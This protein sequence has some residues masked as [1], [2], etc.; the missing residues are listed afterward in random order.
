MVIGCRICIPK[1]CELKRHRG[2]E[3]K[4]EG[5]DV[6]CD[7][8]C[9]LGRHMLEV[10]SCLVWVLGVFA[11]AAEI[12]QTSTKNN[13]CRDDPESNST[14]SAQSFRRLGHQI[15]RSSLKSHG[16]HIHLLQNYESQTQK[17]EHNE[18]NNETARVC[19]PFISFCGYT[20]SSFDNVAILGISACPGG[21]PEV[22]H[23]KKILEDELTR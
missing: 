1:Q 2:R 22:S 19:W 21:I 16:T 6:F 3:R 4:F 17:P 5:H 7:F 23:V 13:I 18:C 9:V 15:C 12:P 8:P 20:F 14:S 10:R 11:V